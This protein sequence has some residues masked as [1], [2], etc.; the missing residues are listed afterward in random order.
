M[1]IRMP[2][3]DGYTATRLIRE[4]NENVPIIALT[5]SIMQE[6]LDKLQNQRFN[7]YVRKPITRQ[8]LFD[9]LTTYISFENENEVQDIQ[10]Q[11][12]EISIEEIVDL[13]DYISY[14]NGDILQKYS[15][16]MSKNDMSLITLFANSLLELSTKHN[17]SYMVK[18]SQDIL[19]YVDAFDIDAMSSMLEKYE[20]NIKKVL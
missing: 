14:I 1:D 13:D 19:E 17:V 8:E 18:Y 3:M 6:E 11:K 20:E 9:T 5:A 15:E 7:G 10:E 2:V 16:A 4:F 12:E